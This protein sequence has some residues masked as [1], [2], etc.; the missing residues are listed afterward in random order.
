ML[1]FILIEIKRHLSEQQEIK[2]AESNVCTGYAHRSPWTCSFADSAVRFYPWLLRKGQT[3]LKLFQ[4]TRDMAH[5]VADHMG[6]LML[7]D[8]RKR[9]AGLSAAEID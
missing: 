3:G 4:Q 8:R 1:S 5:F 2:V 9:R 7:K 6:K